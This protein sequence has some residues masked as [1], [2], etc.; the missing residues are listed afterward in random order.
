MVNL[1]IPKPAMAEGQQSCPTG[2]SAGAAVGNLHLAL[3]LG[4]LWGYIST[5][6]IEREPQGTEV[7]SR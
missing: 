1:Y 3:S 2:L 6:F 7:K 5:L 4:P